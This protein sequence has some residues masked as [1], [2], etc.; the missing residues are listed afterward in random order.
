MLFNNSQSQGYFN[1]FNGPNIFVDAR[2]KQLAMLIQWIAVII[3][4]MP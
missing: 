1:Y 3:L 4:Q 2:G